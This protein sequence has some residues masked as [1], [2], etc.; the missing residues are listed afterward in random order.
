MQKKEQTL[1][2]ESE[3]RSDSDSYWKEMFN[4]VCDK[5]FETRMKIEALKK[6]M[7]HLEKRFATLEVRAQL[8]AKKI[9]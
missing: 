8:L 2:K 5:K 7:D 1:E 6:K 9:K 3:S 4:E